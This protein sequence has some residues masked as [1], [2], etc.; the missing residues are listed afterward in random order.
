MKLMSRGLALALVLGVSPVAVLVAHAARE[1]GWQMSAESM[2]RLQEGKL[3]AARAAL[4][5]SPDQEKLW[6]PIEEQVRALYKERSERR[7]ERQKRREERRA[8]R[9]DG[10]QKSAEGRRERRN[11]AERYERMA[12]RMSERAEQDEGLLER[13]QSAL[14]LAQR[15][16]EGRHRPRHAQPSFRSDGPWPHH[17]WHDGGWG[18]K[19]WGHHRDRDD[20]ERGNAPQERDDDAGEGQNAPTQQ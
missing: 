11:I 17:R 6:A 4:K 1:G 13:L 19:R 16:A 18:G 5:L 12:K 20:H 10:D 15:R 8:E 3:A 7:A 9:K 14:R 2:E